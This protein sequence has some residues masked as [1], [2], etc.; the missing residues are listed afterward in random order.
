MSHLA[1]LGGLPKGELQKSSGSNPRLYR[2]R[3]FLRQ[4]WGLG[5]GRETVDADVNQLAGTRVA[6][7]LVL[8][9]GNP[10][11]SDLFDNNRFAQDPRAQF[12]NWALIAHGAY[13]FAAAARGHT[14][15]AAFEYIAPGWALRAGRFALPDEPNGLPL[16]LALA[17]YHGD[18]IELEKSWLV[19]QQPGAVRLLAW[20]NQMVRSGRHA[21]S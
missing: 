17:R 7:R 19:G 4:S 18:Q 21:A 3:L 12:M 15:G 11:V 9:A 5:G 6:R 8:T 14:W 2:A 1:G 20:R 13:D 10:A 16:D